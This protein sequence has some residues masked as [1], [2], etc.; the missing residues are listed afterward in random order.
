MTFWYRIQIRPRHDSGRLADVFAQ[1]KTCGFYDYVLCL[2]AN[3]VCWCCGLTFQLSLS[4]LQKEKL[5]KLKDGRYRVLGNQTNLDRGL[6]GC[7]VRWFAIHD[8]RAYR[9]HAYRAAVP[10]IEQRFPFVSNAPK[11]HST[12]PRHTYGGRGIHRMFYTL[13]F[14]NFSGVPV[15]NCCP[16]HGTGK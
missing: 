6:C 4:I 7:H 3:R 8:V 9:A 14:L 2:F 12:R 16:Y 10:V 13:I 11:M 15:R 5:C 1:N